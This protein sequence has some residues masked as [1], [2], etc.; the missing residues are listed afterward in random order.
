MRLNR[1]RFA[2]VAS[3]LALVVYDTHGQQPPAPTFRFGVEVTTV[4][5]T[6]VD[7]EGTAPDGSPG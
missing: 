3:L 6:V 1:F 2:V 7:D 5:V 4:D